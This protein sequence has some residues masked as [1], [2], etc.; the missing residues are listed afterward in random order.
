MKK[1]I[2]KKMAIIGLA[3]KIV[4]GAGYVLYLYNMPHRDVQ[5]VKPFADVKAKD[6]INE[7]LVNSEVANAKY[8]SSD[9][10]SKVVVVEGIVNEIV[11]DLNGQKVI[12]LK[13]YGDKIGVSSTFT[14]ETNI[15]VERVKI[16]DR[17]KIKGV[18]RS[19]A[20]YDED[21]E[22]YEDVIIEKSDIVV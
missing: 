3:A 17:V 16:G 9:G 20:E 11:E 2:I 21:L 12:I 18:I 10:D 8:L 13:S 6:L 15:S 7:F 5:S 14:E 4:I 22:L 19:G 1:K